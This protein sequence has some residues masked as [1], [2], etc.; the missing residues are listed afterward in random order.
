MVLYDGAVAS[1]ESK[2]IW[3]IKKGKI[4]ILINSLE[5]IVDRV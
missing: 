3:L 2:A 5:K 4:K 1:L